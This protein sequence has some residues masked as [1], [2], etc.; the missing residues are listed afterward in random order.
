MI[1]DRLKLTYGNERLIR[2][3]NELAKLTEQTERAALAFRE[4]GRIGIEVLAE[5]ERQKI[6]THPKRK[7]ARPKAGKAA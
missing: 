6:P 7:A 5:L 1:I 4:F 3:K 2:F